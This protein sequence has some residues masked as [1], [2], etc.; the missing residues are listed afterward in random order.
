ME[1]A[2]W[3]GWIQKATTALERPKECDARP[4]QAPKRPSGI[5]EEQGVMPAKRVY[6]MDC[7]RVMV[8]KSVFTSLYHMG[9]PY[10]APVLAALIETG[11]YRILFD[12]GLHPLGLTDPE[13]AWGARAKGVT[14][15]PEHSLL[16]TL[17]ELGL[18]VKDVTH[19]VISH[20]HWDHC[21]A[22]SYFRDAKLILQR[23]EY[24]SAFYP[25]SYVASRYFR[26]HFDCGLNFELVEGSYELAEGVWVISTPGHTPGHQSLLVQLPTSTLILPGDAIPLREN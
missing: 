17:E 4:S 20:L 13:A 6:L 12:A 10:D 23:A 24:R 2:C 11:S 15:R 16:N 14:M 8:D 21:G 5:R 7:G 22:L 25:D 18:S 3:D 1:A 19:V 9:T 26:N